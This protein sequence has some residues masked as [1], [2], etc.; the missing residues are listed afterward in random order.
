MDSLSK[1]INCIIIGTLLY[2]EFLLSEQ[3][4]EVIQAQRRFE[5]LVSVSNQAAQRIANVR[6]NFS[7]KRLVRDGFDISGRG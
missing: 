3:G 6:N 7:T 4:N 5:W 2:R 1:Q